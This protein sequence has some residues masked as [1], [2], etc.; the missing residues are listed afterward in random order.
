MRVRKGELDTFF[1]N[2]NQDFTRNIP[3]F[4]EIAGGERIEQKLDL[5]GGNW[6]GLGHCGEYN[7]RRSGG[8]KMNF[9]SS[10]TVAVLYDVPRSDEAAKMGVWYGVAAAFVVVP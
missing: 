4:R 10:D 5:N 8:E 7:E 2:P 9:Q 3:S 6:C 1:Q